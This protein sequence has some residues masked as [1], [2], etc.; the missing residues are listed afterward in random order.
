MWYTA[1]I[2]L[3]A[4]IFWSASQLALFL[5]ALIGLP[6]RTWLSIA[7]RWLEHV[8]VPH[9]IVEIL[10][11]GS[12][13]ACIVVLYYMAGQLPRSAA[14]C[15]SQLWER[16]RREHFGMRWKQLSADGDSYDD[17]EPDKFPHVVSDAPIMYA[18]APH[19]MHAEHLIMGMC[20]NP[21]FDS[22]SVICTSLL[23]WI[24]IVRECTALAGSVPAN[25]V[26]IMEQL[27]EHKRSVAIVP[28]GLRGTLHGPGHGTLK[29]LRGIKDEC[30]PRRGFVRCAFTAKGGPV[31]I[32]P[33][34]VHG[35]EQLYNVWMPWL[36]MQK[37][38]LKR[39]YYPW[40]MIYLGWWGTF[41]PK[42]CKLTFCFGAPIV[43]SKTDSVETV[44]E[45]FC[46]AMEQLITK[47]P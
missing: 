22:V 3:D 20:L 1:L 14:F 35:C 12:P 8:W 39:F 31:P 2:A 28:E 47:K 23:F 7:A 15:H 5:L 16:M 18:V 46:E 37:L 33:V 6:V 21:L 45:R 42:R 9:S 44:H 41:W 27:E 29:V 19:S 25:T 38:T 26:D 40:P 10:E 34:Y 24:P 30:A 17:M 32:V 13:V 4:L 11:H 43:P 36:W